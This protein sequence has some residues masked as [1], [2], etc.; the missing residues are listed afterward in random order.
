MRDFLAER[1]EHHV[2]S[3]EMP[4]PLKRKIVE[5]LKPYIDRFGYREKVEKALAA[6][7]KPTAP[8][9]QPS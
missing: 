4:L 8:T 3:Y 1:S 5:R 2:S 7:P 6:K 9:R